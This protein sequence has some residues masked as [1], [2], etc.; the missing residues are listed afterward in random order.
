VEL[1]Q[2][3]TS[4]SGETIKWVHRSDWSIMLVIYIDTNRNQIIW[5]S[6]VLTNKFV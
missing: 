6:M 2:F 5:S 3:N 1:A 4:Y